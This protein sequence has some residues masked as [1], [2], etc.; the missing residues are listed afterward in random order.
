MEAIIPKIRKI[1]IRSAF[2]P[3]VILSLPITPTKLEEWG[4]PLDMTF[5]DL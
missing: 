5:G 4:F 2:W 1:N 3:R